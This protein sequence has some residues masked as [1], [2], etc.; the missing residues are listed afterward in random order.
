MWYSAVEFLVILALSLLAAPLAAAQPP[1]KIP[2]IGVLSPGS[3]SAT[4]VP[5]SPVVQGLRDL[6]Y[7]EGQHIT[8]AYRSAE[9]N[10]DRLPDLAAEL[11]R[12]PVDMILAGELPAHWL[13]SK[14]PQR[15]P[16]Y[17]LK[18]PIQSGAGWSPA[19]HGQAGTSPG[20][21][22]MAGRRS[23]A[24]GWSCSKQPCLPSPAWQCWWGTC[25]RQP[26]MRVSRRR[27]VRHAR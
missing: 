15:S 14:P 12:L 25:A 16:L 4:S 20:C 23:W 21:P 3:P 27:R 8:F 22:T 13:P 9:G 1:A 6:G 10:L 7:V 19:S 26:L 18:P 2:R 17:S 11:V 5:M 24:N